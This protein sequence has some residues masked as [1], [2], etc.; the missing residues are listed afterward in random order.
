[1]SS[2]E[3]INVDLG[4]VKEQKVELMVFREFN[5]ILLNLQTIISRN[6]TQIEN[7]LSFWLEIHLVVLFQVSFLILIKVTMELATLFHSS[8]IMMTN[9]SINYL[10]C[11]QHYSQQLLINFLHFKKKKWNIN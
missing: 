4:T 5:Q 3:W 2:L 8:G 6:M 10:Q 9:G 1:M 7:Y 11:Y